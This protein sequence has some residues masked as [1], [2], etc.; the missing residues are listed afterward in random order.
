MV[1]IKRHML[2]RIE[3]IICK[4]SSPITTK[5]INKKTGN[6]LAIV[7]RLTLRQ[8]AEKQGQTSSCDSRRLSLFTIDMYKSTTYNNFLIINQH[9]QH[10]QLVSNELLSSI[11]GCLSSPSRTGNLLANNRP[12]YSLIYVLSIVS[13]RP[14][15]RFAPPVRR[16]SDHR[17]DGRAAGRGLSTSGGPPRTASQSVGRSDARRGVVVVRLDPPPADDSV[18]QWCIRS[19]VPS[20][21]TVVPPRSRVEDGTSPAQSCVDVDE[22]RNSTRRPIP[23]DEPSNRSSTKRT[24]SI[25]T[26]RVGTVR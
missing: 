9:H 11:Q 14:S 13:C 16:V 23:S 5:L 18:L 25:V 19:D 7:V 17:D 20:V 12:N 22:K 21:A 24:R 1:L 8:S 3:L 26:R 6:W 2:R 10:H 4:G 15:L